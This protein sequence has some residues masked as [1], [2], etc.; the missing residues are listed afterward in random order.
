MSSRKPLVTSEFRFESL[1]ASSCMSS[2]PA[3]ISVLVVGRLTA[4]C[5]IAE[6]DK[7]TAGISLALCELRISLK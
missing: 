6:N 4:T 7:D 2:C 1:V 3:S 5:W